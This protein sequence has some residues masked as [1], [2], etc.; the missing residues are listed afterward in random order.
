MWSAKSKQ[1][2]EWKLCRTVSFIIKKASINVGRLHLIFQVLH[3][4]KEL[5]SMNENKFLV[6]R[7]KKQ[8]N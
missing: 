4:L 5:A 2:S 1:A 3:V 7:K 8:T 6:E